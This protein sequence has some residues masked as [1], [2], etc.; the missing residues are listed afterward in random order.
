MS[1]VISL[2]DATYNNLQEL[3]DN[4]GL[5]TKEAITYLLEFYN[6]EHIDEFIKLIKCKHKN[7]ELSPTQRAGLSILK[8]Y[9]DLLCS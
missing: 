8:D 3:K 2:P 6:L 1:R 5:K 7:I 4:K 9:L